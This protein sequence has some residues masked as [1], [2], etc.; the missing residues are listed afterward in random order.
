MRTA[1]LLVSVLATLSEASIF[2]RHKTDACRCEGRYYIN[3]TSYQDGVNPLT[4][5]TPTTKPM[6]VDIWH[7]EDNDPLK[8][9]MTMKIANTISAVVTTSNR[10]FCGTDV[11]IVQGLV[12]TR[13]LAFGT[14][15]ANERIMKNNVLNGLD[16]W[17]C[18]Y[19]RGTLTLGSPNASVVLYKPK[20]E[21]VQP[22]PATTSTAAPTG[23]IVAAA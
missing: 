23:E 3:A 8:V 4:T 2:S 7:S 13:M 1:A 20:Q 17:K 21:V 15:G 19:K 14:A 6:T 10:D 22:L 18:D 5:M 11:E 12:S 9:R 16:G